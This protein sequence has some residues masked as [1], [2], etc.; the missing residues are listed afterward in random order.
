[1]KSKV[2]SLKRSIESTSLY[3]V[4]LTKRIRANAQITE[5]R[6]NSGDINSDFIEINLVMK[7]P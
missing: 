2:S 4:R 1:M 3:L 6:N 7:L 5:V